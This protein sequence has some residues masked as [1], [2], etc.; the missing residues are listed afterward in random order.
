MMSKAADG[1][2]IYENGNL[3]TKITIPTSVTSVF[4][5]QFYR[6]VDMTEITLHDGITSIAGY[7]F[8][9]CTS[10]KINMNLSNLTSI[11]SNAFRRVK[12]I[13][14]INLPNLTSLNNAAFWGSGVK[15]VSNLG[16]ITNLAGGQWSQDGVF[17][18][19]TNLVSVLLPD[20]LESITN[21][22]N[23]Y[24]NCFSG[25]TALEN[26]NINHVKTIGK[27]CFSKCSSLSIHIDNPYLTV[28]DNTVFYS[29]GEITINTPNVTQVG[30]EC[31]WNSKLKGIL[32]MPNV[33]SIGKRAFNSTNIEKVILQKIKTIQGDSTWSDHGAFYKCLKL[34][35]VTLSDCV[36][37]I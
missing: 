10:A 26:I 35:H 5:S 29:C 37:F 23:G 31:F 11:G 32:N 15:K 19:C 33:E 21:E 16:K 20:C 18:G 30:V 14:D 9:D 25:C 2:H 28:L 27:S 34:T 36:E 3:V 17:N 12:E 1:A 7:A 13:E 24:S 22:S 4:N 6:Y 8:D